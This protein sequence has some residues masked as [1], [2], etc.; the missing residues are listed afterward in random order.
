MVLVRS[1]LFLSHFFFLFSPPFLLRLLQAFSSRL[2]C[3]VVAYGFSLSLYLYEYVKGDKVSLFSS[4]L[5]TVGAAVF[6]LYQVKVI[7]AWPLDV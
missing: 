4:Q 3:S 5:Q 2:V 1:V 6:S 7:S